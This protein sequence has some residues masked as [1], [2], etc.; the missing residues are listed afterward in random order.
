MPEHPKTKRDPKTGEELELVEVSC[1]NCDG[2]G[3]K[4]KDR[5]GDI[6]YCPICDGSGIRRR[7]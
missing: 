1:D 2:T 5:T 3:E 6:F 4:G 7:P